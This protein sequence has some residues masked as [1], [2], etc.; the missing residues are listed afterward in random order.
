MTKLALGGQAQAIEPIPGRR[1][2]PRVNAP[3]MH[4]VC[5]VGAGPAGLS[6]ALWL[7]RCG[8]DVAVFDSGKPRNA[9]SRGLHGFLTRDG[10]HPLQL[11]QMGRA[12]LA[13]YPTVQVRDV[14]VVEA[15]RRDGLFHLRLADGS[16]ESSAMLLLATGRLDLV[17]EKPGFAALYGRGVYHCPFCDGWEHRGESLVAMGCDAFAYDLALALLTWSPHVSLCTD[18]PATLEPK[19]R[20]KLAA[21]DIEVIEKPILAARASA[22]G[23][24]AALEFDGR[25]A[26]DCQALFFCFA[27]PQK[28]GLPG[29]LG[30]EF[31]ETGAVRCNDHAATNVPGLFVAGNVR[32]G[33]HLAITAAA[34][35]AEAAVAINDALLERRLK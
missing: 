31:D 11:R 3:A 8:R 21:N 24:L 12:E 9:A 20:Q 28:S 32:C 10:L 5:I 13:A 2:G 1:V 17:P 27:N 25:A 22:D 35:G 6:A 16:E 34:E 15:A 26:L 18:G 29:S 7:G 30:C 33:L 19:Q 23:L 14:M 4:D